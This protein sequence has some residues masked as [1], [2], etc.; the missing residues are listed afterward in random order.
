M[1]IVGPHPEPHPRPFAPLLELPGPRP[2][3]SALS[4]EDAAAWA[5]GKQEIYHPLA[6][7]F[8]KLCPLSKYDSH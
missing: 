2:F 8:Q 7:V 5:D 4:F 1:P 6:L 3:S